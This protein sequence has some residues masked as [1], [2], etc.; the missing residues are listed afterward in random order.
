[1]SL[2]ID[3]FYPRSFDEIKFNHDVAENLKKFSEYDNIS[4]ILL[5]GLKG[6][7]KN[8]FANLYIDYKYG[9][10]I[11]INT[12][13]GINKGVVRH[14]KNIIV[15]NK[16]NQT[17]NIRVVYSNY[18]LQLNPSLYGVYDR[19]IIK[20]Y[21][22]D[23]IKTKSLSGKYIT[24][25]IEDAD[26]LSI[27]A[28][29]SLRRTLEIN[30]NTCRFIF[31]VNQTGTI[32]SP[33]ISRF[34]Q[35]RLSL[36]TDLE[37]F[38]I[39]KHINDVKV[40][41]S[42]IK[43]SSASDPVINDILKISSRNLKTAINHINLYHMFGKIID[44]ETKN[45]ESIVSM[46]TNNFSPSLIENLRTILFDMLVHCIEPS[47]ISKMIYDT[48]I[49]THN[50]NSKAFSDITD[51]LAICNDNLKDCNKPVYHLERFCIFIALEVL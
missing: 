41:S 30:M 39:L 4:H 18:H 44:N 17:K 1:M 5:S 33:L 6:S 27:D 12:G 2:Y 49:S 25:I 38:N 11:N 46:L 16:T 32:I 8:T 28:Q 42:E 13:K 51:E 3:E 10:N 31:L 47:D 26:K 20:K 7:G 15:K 23:V 19:L 34:V 14:T 48:L 43:V 9:I 50:L 21:V 35:F 29:E 45:I 37:M 24:V 40:K 36:P 22:N